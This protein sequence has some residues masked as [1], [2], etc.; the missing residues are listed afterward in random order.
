MNLLTLIWLSALVLSGAALLL[1]LLLVVSRLFSGR[2]Q[3]RL[4]ER[5]RALVRGVL[6]GKESPAEGLKRVPADIVAEIFTDLIRLVRGEER[7]AFVEQAQRLGVPDRLGRRLRSMSARKRLVAAQS[8]GQFHDSDSLERLHASL[9]DSNEDVRLAA[10]LALAE[11]GQTE[12]IHALVQELGLGT[13]ED[14]ML[15]VT[16]F[17]VIADERPEEIKALVAHPD[18]NLVARL[19]AIEAL[20]TT[21]DYSL[22]PTIVQLVL[23]APDGAEELPRYLRALGTIGHPAAMPA[24]MNGL[25]RPAVGARATAAGAA[26]RI[27]L[28]GAGARLT[29]LL[30]D[31]EWWVRFRAAEALVRIGGPAIN[32]LRAVAADGSP[33]ARDAAATTLAEHGMAAA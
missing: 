14:S 25:D 17:R 2:R 12:D 9:K 11:A 24:I 7:R 22:V 28:A 1:L 21:G 5:R 6:S 27:G 4:D 29:E 33:R 3:R 20:A 19:A 10:A 18:T 15:I 23:D 26:G 31:P 13:E 30:D 8:L 32:R 16:L